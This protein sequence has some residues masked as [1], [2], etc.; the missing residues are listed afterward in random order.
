MQPDKL[1]QHMMD[2]YRELWMW[3]KHPGSNPSSRVFAVLIGWLLGASLAL[4]LLR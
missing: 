3:I 1:F 4:L 2:D